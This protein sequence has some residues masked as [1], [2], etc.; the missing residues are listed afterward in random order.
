MY[1]IFKKHPGFYVTDKNLPLANITV[2][3]IKIIDGV[4]L[5]GSSLIIKIPEKVALYNLTEISYP[6]L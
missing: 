2:F 5:K 3:L 6:L 4:S 1:C